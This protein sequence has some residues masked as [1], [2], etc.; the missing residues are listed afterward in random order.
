MAS[1]SFLECGVELVQRETGEKA[2]TAHVDG[3]N[4]Y[5]AKRGQARSGQHGS[6]ASKNQQELRRVGHTDARLAVGAVWQ[7]SS[8]FFV[9]NGGDTAN[10]KPLQQRWNDDGKLS[11]A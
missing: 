8:Y 3:Q 6:V 4:G 11:A 10:L 7:S 5:P 2:Q 9:K 1:E